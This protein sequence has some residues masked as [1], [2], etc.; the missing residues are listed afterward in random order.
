M[1]KGGFT[2]LEAVLYLAIAGTVLYFISGFAFNAIFGKSKIETIQ[3]IN[4]NSRAV[5]DKMS[6]AV[7]NSEGING[8]TS[9][10]AGGSGEP[11]G[12]VITDHLV[13]YWNMNDIIYSTTVSASGPDF[14]QSGFTSQNGYGGFQDP[15][16]YSPCGGSGGFAKWD[17]TVPASGVYN[18]YGWWGNAGSTNNAHY[19]ITNN[20]GTSSETIDQSVNQS[21]WNPIG[22]GFSFTTGTTYH[23]ILSDTCSGPYN[24]A[25]SILI[26]KAGSVVDSVGG[27]N[28]VAA[29]VT[30][31]SGLVG[32]AFSFNGVN[33][34]IDAGPSSN[35]DFTTQD[36]SASLWIYPKSA[37]V[38]PTVQTIFSKG[39]V[40]V[41]GYYLNWFT[42]Q[43]GSYL[44]FV[45]NV[46]G[47]YHQALTGNMP[48]LN[49]W[50]HIVV[51]KSGIT[52]L[53][54]YVDN[55]EVTYTSQNNSGDIIS[56]SEDMYIGSYDKGAF[57]FNGLI[58]EFGIYDKVLSTAEIQA[59]YNTEK[60]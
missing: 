16:Y 46:P 6:S 19:T 13:S 48:S 1:K 33:S 37:G 44:Q 47:G 29:G 2:L 41:S 35:L 17:F 32:G 12:P 56:T 20:S 3:D 27:N 23:V 15:H 25:D 14:S 4:Q 53:K 31:V 51:V 11:S 26:A 10:P 30:S 36:F 38:Y 49:F 59:I 43:S 42:G 45:V 7:G 58:D 34:A 21:R 9:N 8:I 28:G 5:L 57:P 50:H 52:P 55:Q 18:V 54:I 40:N 39:A 60:P 24:I 22:S